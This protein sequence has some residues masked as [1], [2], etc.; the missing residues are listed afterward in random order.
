MINKVAIPQEELVAFCQRN[1]IRKLS[2]FGSVL[3]EDFRPDS[4]LDVLVEYEPGAV[5]TLLDMAAQEIELGEMMGRKVDLR[6]PED[7]SRYF[8]NQVVN[9]AQRLYERN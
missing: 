8:R 4:D 2:L 9:T 1:H 6:T 5:I 3:R 7:L